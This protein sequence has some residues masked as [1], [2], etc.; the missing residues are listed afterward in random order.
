MFFGV[1]AISTVKMIAAVS[2]GYKQKLNWTLFF[3]Y[4]KSSSETYALVNWV[5][6]YLNNSF[7]ASLAQRCVTSAWDKSNRYLC[8]GITTD[9]SDTLLDINIYFH[10]IYKHN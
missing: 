1:G 6:I 8:W 4:H 10:L 9:I 7:A 5:V 3:I 2:A